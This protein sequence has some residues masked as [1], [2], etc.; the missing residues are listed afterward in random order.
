[1]SAIFASMDWRICVIALLIFGITLAVTRYVSLGSILIS[2][3]FFVEYVIFSLHSSFNWFGVRINT[4]IPLEITIEGSIVIFILTF[5]AI[6]KHKANIVRLIQG[7]ENKVGK[8]K[9]A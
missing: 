9:E 8:K 5:I 3:A 4:E 6:Y 2:L 7:T 1:M